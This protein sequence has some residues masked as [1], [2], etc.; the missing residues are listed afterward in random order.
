[1]DRRVVDT[2]AREERYAIL[3]EACTA[4]RKPRDADL[5]R[6]AEQ[7]DR[8]AAALPF[9]IAA[10]AIA[11]GDPK[12]AKELCRREQAKHGRQWAVDLWQEIKRAVIASLDT[13]TVTDPTRLLKLDNMGVELGHQ[14][15]A[16]CGH[17]QFVTHRNRGIWEP[18]FTC[19]VCGCGDMVL[20][21]EES[22]NE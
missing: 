15:C 3:L 10:T 4:E 16:R 19:A 14:T 9:S 12:P 5:T 8:E 2:E 20:V 18:G 21:M 1:M 11:N 17:D 7:A 22:Q 13:A 6:I